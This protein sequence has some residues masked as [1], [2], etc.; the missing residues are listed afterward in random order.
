MLEVWKECTAKSKGEQRLARRLRE[1]C[2]KDSI[3]CFNVDFIPGGREIDLLLIHRKLGVYIIEVKAIPL[4]AIKSISPSRWQIANRS[5]DE[6]PLIQA[7]NQYEGLRSYW[8]AR[9]RTRL[10]VVAV[11]ACFPEISR[12]EWIQAFKKAAYPLSLTDR[13]IFREDLV[14]SDRLIS[15]LENIMRYPPI[16]SGRNPK[17]PANQFLSDLHG[18]MQSSVPQLATESDRARLQAIEKTITRQL[19]SEF[20]PGGTK[21]VTFSGPPGTGK[22]FRLLAIG[23]LHAY[24]GQRVLFV[25]FNKTLASDIRRLL[26]FED[27]LKLATYELEALDVNQIALRCFERN[28]L[29]YLE[30]GD[31]DD[32]G[33][34]VV[35]HLQKLGDAAI[36]DQYDTVLIDEA[37][38][39]QDWQ[40]ELIRMNATSTAT[41]CLALGKGQ[42]L[43]RDDTS[44][45]DWL[46]NVA[47]SIPI[48][49]K[50]L[51]KNFRN[52]TEQF[53][54]ALAFHKAWPD[55][56][57]QVTLNY[58]QLV[59][60][61]HQREI[62]FERRGEPLQY[63]AVPAIPGEFDNF[64]SEQL[65]LVSDEYSDIIG[66]EIDSLKQD[67]NAHPV[68]ILVLVPDGGSSTYAWVRL[69]LEKATSKRPGVSFID[70]TV[71]KARRG[72]AKSEEIRL[73]TFHSARGLEGERVLIFGL[74]NIESLA[75]NTN[76]K[77]ENLGFIALSRGIYRTA[78]VV[79]TFFTN[80]TH[81]LLKAI[82]LA[83][84]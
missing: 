24:A 31:A 6:S 25:C 47:N 19:S 77:P 71:D 20:P 54:A 49:T 56:L 68:G 73:C 42:E 10:P 66:S 4:H 53:F 58:Q 27:K 50:R 55:N 60:N 37:H 29:P 62:E 21:F 7:Y 11:T 18:M 26:S 75:R 3:L 57:S 15:R 28:G 69:A 81:K 2:S 36:R 82:L 64:G 45:V 41:V 65:E 23:L 12:S 34:M 67:V 76:V 48:Q 38:D 13:M 39:M 79:R 78:I 32:W 46:K 16:R 35:D 33:R 14:D 40:L 70:Y 52:P 43:Y 74:E 17:S 30:D 72:V 1:V 59:K 80:S 22:T 61:K 51:R 83:R 84:N 5:S 63:I 8:D 44:A 9:M